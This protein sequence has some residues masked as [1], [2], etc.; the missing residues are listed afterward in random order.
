LIVNIV[1][2]AT[3]PATG[4]TVVTDGAADVVVNDRMLPSVVPPELAPD[5]RK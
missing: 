2:P 5:T 4:D 3:G 1:P